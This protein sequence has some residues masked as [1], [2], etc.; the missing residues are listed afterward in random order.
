M[1]T[2]KHLT[3]FRGWLPKE[4]NT[5]NVKTMASRGDSGRR[6]RVV[7][8]VGGSI[9]LAVGVFFL[10]IVVGFILNPI[11][12]ADVR[13]P[14]LLTEKEDFLLGIDGVVGAGIARN[15]TNH[16]AGIAV[17]VEDNSASV[18]DIPDELG[19]FTVYIKSINEASQHEIDNII[20]RRQN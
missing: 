8:I 14:E 11:V 18:Q 2:K 17:Y 10:V 4:G 1:K 19:G 6:L 20:I 12:P 7:A 16:I 5:P 3:P 9:A 15:S 13:I